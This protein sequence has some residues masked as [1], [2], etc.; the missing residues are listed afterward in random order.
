MED[1]AQKLPIPNQ[2]RG[3]K[4]HWVSI[5]SQISTLTTTTKMQFTY[6]NECD[7][8]MEKSMFAMCAFL[9]NAFLYGKLLD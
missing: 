3:S 5:F 9:R 4:L 1:E 7:L 2:K 6:L 8:L